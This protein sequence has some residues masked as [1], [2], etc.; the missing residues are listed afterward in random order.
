MPHE[1]RPEDEQG[2]LWEEQREEYY[3]QRRQL[4]RPWGGSRLGEVFKTAGAS[5]AGVENVGARGG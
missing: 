5:V 3:R 4:Q 1:Q 2:V